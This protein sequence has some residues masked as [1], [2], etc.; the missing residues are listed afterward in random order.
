MFELV[1]VFLH[2]LLADKRGNYVC[3][4]YLLMSSVADR[5]VL[6]QLV[7]PIFSSLV[8]HVFAWRVIQKMVNAIN[9]QPEV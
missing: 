2:A 4:K 6:W 7:R 8:V 1:C 3:Q 5:I 9:S